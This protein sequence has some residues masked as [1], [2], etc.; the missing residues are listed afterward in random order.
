MLS[1]FKLTRGVCSN[2]DNFFHIF[3]CFV[4]LRCPRLRHLRRVEHIFNEN[5]VARGGIVDENVGDR[6][7]KLTVLDDG[8]AAHECGQ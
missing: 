8:G 3:S 4:A 6:P 7:D 1:L 2:R 5:A